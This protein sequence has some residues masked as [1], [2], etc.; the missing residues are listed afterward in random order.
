MYR[1]FGQGQISILGQ[2]S[3]TKNKLNP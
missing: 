1:S 2:S 3:G